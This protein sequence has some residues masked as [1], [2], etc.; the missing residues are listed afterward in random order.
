MD[1][2]VESVKKTNRCV[3]AHEAIVRGG[4]GGEI[5][6]GIV[7]RAF[8]YLDA[9]IVRLG[10]V[11]V[12]MPYSVPLEAVVIPKAADVARAVREVLR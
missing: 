12:P 1:T 10:S 4:V 7:E 9:P 5:T 8:D 11:P 6:A 3:V 2:I